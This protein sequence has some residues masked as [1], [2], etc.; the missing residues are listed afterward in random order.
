MRS[1]Q[2]AVAAFLVGTIVIPGLGE[3]QRRRG[4]YPCASGSTRALIEV[5]QVSDFFACGTGGLTEAVL[6]VRVVRVRGGPTRARRL[7]VVMPCPSPDLAVGDRLEACVGEPSP[8]L[9][10]FRFDD[11]EDEPG[12]RLYVRSVAILSRRARATGEP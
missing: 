1:W 6:R 12:E 9:P 10:H 5:R 11:F 3:A 4:A 8:A 7:L 2:L